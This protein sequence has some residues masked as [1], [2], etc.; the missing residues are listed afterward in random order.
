MW[1]SYRRT[2]RNRTLLKTVEDERKESLPEPRR[3]FNDSGSLE[4]GSDLLFRDMASP[5]QPHGEQT[6][7]YTPWPLSFPSIFCLNSPL[8]QTM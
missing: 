6:G 4:R 2:I 3:E 5:R 1:A 7:I 8:A